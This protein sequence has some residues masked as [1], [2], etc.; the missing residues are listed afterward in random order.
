MRIH[1]AA[2]FLLAGAAC[3]ADQADPHH[4]TLPPHGGIPQ[5]T[6]GQVPAPAFS[7]GT[8]AFNLTGTTTPGDFNVVAAPVTDP[9]QDPT[10]Y[11]TGAYDVTIDPT[12]Y[13]G[14]L[15]SLAMTVDDGAG[16]TYLVFGGYNIYTGPA[17]D[18]LDQVVALVKQSDFAVGATV[19]LDGNDRIALFGTGDPAASEPTTTGAAV[20]GSITFTSGSL[21]IGDTITAT[22]HGDFGLVDWGT[23]PAGTGTIT[24]GNYTLAV[25]PTASV[26]CDGTLAGHEADFAGIT[27]SSLAFSGGAVAVANNA[28]GNVTVDG[29][30]I[31]GAFATSPL[32]LDDAGGGILAGFTDQAGA[33]PLGTT[34]AGKYFA[35]DTS[36]ATTSLVNGAVGAGYATA[37]GDGTC[38]VSFQATLTQ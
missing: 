28:A 19:A 5:P 26:Y 35:V 32:E 8:G 24:A 13:S 4:V 33:G 14:A 1:L 36:S 21:A 15:Q 17:G 29:T 27:A 31:S 3:T 2:T 16:D 6:N 12:N 23:P 20:T 37:A 34:M 25:D 7:F 22:V 9:S 18:Q 10:S 38:S 30:A 11:G